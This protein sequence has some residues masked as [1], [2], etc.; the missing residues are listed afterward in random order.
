MKKLRIGSLVANPII[1]GG[2]AVEISMAGLC[3]A[4]ANKGGI[5]LLPASGLTADRLI[6]EIRLTRSMTNGVVGVNVMLAVHECRALSIAAIE[7]KIDLLVIGAGFTLKLVKELIAKAHASNIPVVMIISS[8][9]GASL[10]YKVGVD[11]VIAEGGDAGGH[12]GTDKTIWEI[13]PEIVSLVPPS[14]PV[15]A[16]GGCGTKDGFR[17]AVEL[18]ASGIQVGTRFALTK[19]ARSS[20]AR[21]WQE[22]VLNTDIGII[23][24]P[25]G[26]PIRVALTSSIKRLKQDGVS[27][28]LGHKPQCNRSC[29]YN[30]RY[31]DSNF[32]EAFC[33]FKMLRLAKKGDIENGVFTVGSQIPRDL[34]VDELPTVTEVIDE[35]LR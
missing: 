2:M 17:K 7:E 10:A 16:A 22:V 33:I 13:L 6:K 25:V 24:S 15:I 21:T 11:A 3:A 4:V 26:M 32:S 5:G 18:G 28:V 29:L 8:G 12:L 20:V 27:H 35:I 31:R 9:K 14:F 34:S 30:C 19:D 23:E 1:L